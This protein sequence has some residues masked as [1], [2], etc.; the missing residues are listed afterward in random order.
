MRVLLAGMCLFMA[1]CSSLTA[2]GQARGLLDRLEF[3]EG[4]EGCF[5]LTGQIDLNPIP[6]MT[7]TVNIKLHKKK[8][9]DAPDC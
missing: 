1:G 7:S 2:E 4:E 5:E 9:E 6:F 3:D 8:G